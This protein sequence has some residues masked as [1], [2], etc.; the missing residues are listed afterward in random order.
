MA[1]YTGA[2]KAIGFLF[3]MAANIADDYDSASI[4]ASDDFVIYEGTL[5][6]CINAI[7]TP[8]DFTPAHWQAV[9]I[10]DEISSGGGGGGTTVIANPAGQATADLEKLQVSSTIYAIPSGGGGGQSYSTTEHIIGTWIDGSTLYEI[11]LKKENLSRVTTSTVL[12]LRS[13]MPSNIDKIIDMRALYAENR[14]NGGVWTENT[15]GASNSYIMNTWLAGSGP[16][17]Y[18]WTQWG[19]GPQTMTAY[20]TLKYTKTS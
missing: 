17:I 9:L 3:N 15:Y 5:Y 18:R 8:E 11:T 14:A 2:D 16:D 19:T 12:F 7:V 13:E 6:K 20:V 4:Y 1:T 10:M